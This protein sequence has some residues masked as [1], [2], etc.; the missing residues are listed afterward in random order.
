MGKQPFNL[1]CFDFKNVESKANLTDEIR[2][3]VPHDLENGRQLFKIMNEL[4]KEGLV[5]DLVKD[6]YLTDINTGLR[7]R[8]KKT[9]HGEYYYKVLGFKSNKTIEEI[10]KEEFNKYISTFNTYPIKKEVIAV[11]NIG[12][13]KACAE[14]VTANNKLYFSLEIESDDIIGPYNAL[15]KYM[16][17]HNLTG[18]INTDPILKF[19]I[20]VQRKNIKD[21]EK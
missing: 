2:L 13:Y 11:I 18:Y 3:I 17:D 6:Y 21:C 16:N 4:K 7:F 14:L 5:R 10:T 1:E 19:A 9:H 12:G 8:Y 15:L 20:D